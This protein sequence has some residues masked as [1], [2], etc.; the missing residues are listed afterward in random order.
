[1]RLQQKCRLKNKKHKDNLYVFVTYVDKRWKK[2]KGEKKENK[3]AETI[4]QNST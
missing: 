3:K 1:M 2:R 4:K